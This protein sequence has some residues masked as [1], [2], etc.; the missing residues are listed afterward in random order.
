LIGEPDDN[1]AFAGHL[2]LL[3]LE[4]EQRRFVRCDL[5]R[6]AL[7]LSTECR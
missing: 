1:G 3:D 5:S 6:D 4:V 2:G 7:N